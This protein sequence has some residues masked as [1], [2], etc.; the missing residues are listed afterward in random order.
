M[1]THTT[2]KDFFLHLSATVVLYTAAIALINLAMTVIN[3][4]LPDELAGYFYANSAAWPISMLIVLVPLLYVLEW[5]IKKDTLRMPE[6]LDIWIRK[7]R[8][9]LTLFLAGAVIVGDIIALIN[10]YLNGEIT[11]RFVWKVLAVLVVTGVIF[12]YY[13]FERMDKSPRKRAWQRVMAWAGIVLVLAAI[14]GGFLAVGSPGTQR[15]LRF[16]QRRVNDLS[17]L[18]WQ[19]I[20]HWQTKGSL[21]ASLDDLDDSISGYKVPLDPETDAEYGYVRKANTTFE[22]CATFSRATEDNRGRGEFGGGGGFGIARPSSIYFP[23]PDIDNN[24]EHDKG[25][26]CFERKIDPDKYPIQPKPLR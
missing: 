8:V 18:Q 14:V 12:T 3:Y 23:V 5:L 16:D 24:W 9:F 1:N 10:T 13:I 20:N 11:S 26:V 4:F 6:K 22:L 17:N 15:A 19:I 25:N 21:P 7:W 2:P